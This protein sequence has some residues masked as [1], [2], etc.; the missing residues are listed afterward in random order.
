VVTFSRRGGDTTRPADVAAIGSS[1]G[2]IG[3]VVAGCLFVGLAAA[4]VLEVLV[5]AGAREHVITGAAMLAFAGGWALLR[6]LS[7]WLTDQPQ[8]WAV[9]PALNMAVVGAALLAFAS[10]DKTLHTLGWIWPFPLIA[11]VLWMVRGSRHELRSRTRPLLLYPV[12]AF[13]AL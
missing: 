10:G 11:V 7:E 12:F 5:F 6:V 8:R 1:S 2:H 4:L 13:L 3:R 9:V